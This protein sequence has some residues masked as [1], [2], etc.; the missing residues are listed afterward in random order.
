MNLLGVLATN[1]EKKIRP[2]VHNLAQGARK[3]NRGRTPPLGAP[4]GFPH[5]K[6]FHPLLIFKELN[7]G[8]PPLRS[9]SSCLP[10]HL[11]QHLNLTPINYKSTL[12]ER[13]KVGGFPE[14][15]Y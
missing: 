11:G 13:K 1:K 12:P 10:F 15:S 3:L 4:L 8:S 6:G 14:E 9:L 7:Q 5:V 2:L